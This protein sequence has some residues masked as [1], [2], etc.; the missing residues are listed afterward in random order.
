MS[1]HKKKLAK[2]KND[3]KQSFNQFMTEQ[4]K[5]LNVNANKQFVRKH[6]STKKLHNK[7]LGVLDRGEVW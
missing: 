6:S 1:H 5:C 3:K 4:S 2:M 7:V